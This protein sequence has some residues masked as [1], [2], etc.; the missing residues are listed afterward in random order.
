[1]KN[2]KRKGRLF[3]VGNSGGNNKF[4]GAGNYIVHLV[5]LLF[6]SLALAGVGAILSDAADILTIKRYLK[7]PLLFILNAIPVILLLLMLYHLSSRLWVSFFLGGGLYILLNIINRFKML[8]REEPLTL[9]DF[10]LGA[11]AANVVVFSELPFNYSIIFSGVLWLAVSVFLFFVLKPV[12]LRWPVKAAGTVIPILIFVLCFNTIYKDQNLY[13]SFE[14][15]GSI[16]SQV[17]KFK[18]RGFTY[19]FLVRARSYKSIKPDNYSKTEAE[20]ILAEYRN[21]DASSR[22]GKLP[23]IVA[24]MGEAFYDIDRIEGIEFNEGHDPLDNFNRIIKKAYA[25]RIVTNVFGGGTANTEFSFLTGHSM[26]IMPNM[27]SPYTYYLRKDTFSLARV[28]KKAGYATLAFHPGDS[29]FYNRTN[30]YDFFGFDNKYFKNDMDLNNVEMNHGYISDKDT[31]K[32]ALEKLKSHIS[33]NPDKPLFEFVV[34]IDNHGP[35]AKYD[36]GYPEILK[37]SGSMDDETY[38]IV[39]NYLYGLNRCDEALGYF[40]DSLDKIGEPVIFLFFADH[41]P[42]LGENFKGYKALGFEISQTGSLE[43]YLNHY[44]T[45]YFIYCNEEAKELL[46]ERNIQAPEGEAPLISSNYLAAE[47]L[48]YIGLDGGAYFNFLTELQDEIPV[49]TNRFYEVNGSFT[50]NLPADSLQLIDRYRR[51]QYYMMM[52]PKAVE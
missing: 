23:H 44:E 15:Q 11:E 42:F 16:Y 14:V 2:C 28:L 48:K 40:V 7:A 52:E 41:L 22:S 45:P 32:F 27:S 30:V 9:E 38:Y 47:L 46:K 26:P 20:Q 12:K 17:N 6:L 4:A 21:N 50:E 37:R 39:N 36:L 8:L 43:A 3:Q 31:A 49:I 19:S 5:L 18:S 1:V 24:V 13:N 35:Y 10:L 25:G 34:N 33:Q 29:W 51:L